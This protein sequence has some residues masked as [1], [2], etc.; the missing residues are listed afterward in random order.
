DRWDE[1]V[2]NN[3]TSRPDLNAVLATARATGA[4]HALLGSIIAAGEQ[5]RVSAQLFDLKSGLELPV[6]TVEGPADHFLSL[7]DGLSLAIVRAILGNEAD[8][9]DN[10]FRLASLTTSSLP[11]LRSY[12]EAEAFYRR[13]QFPE[14]LPLLDRAIAADPDF[15]LAI[16]RR[17]Q[18]FGWLVKTP[19]DTVEAARR[20]IE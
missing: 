11:A 6:P 12:L 5:V 19:R 10:A 18:V 9:A 14:A 2:G 13:A 3:K 7:V 17:A 8:V 4:S 1:V 20:A 15:G 16:M